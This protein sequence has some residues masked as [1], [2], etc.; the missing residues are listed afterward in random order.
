MAITAVWASVRTSQRGESPL[1]E[2]RHRYSTVSLAFHWGLALLVLAQV[3][4]FI[5]RDNVLHRM[6]PVIPRRP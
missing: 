2:P 3:L 6:I 1:T 4:L 5:D